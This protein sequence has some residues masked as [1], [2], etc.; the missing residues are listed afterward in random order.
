MSD[1]RELD[2]KEVAEDIIRRLQEW[3]DAHPLGTP[4]FRIAL[5][6]CGG[7]YLRTYGATA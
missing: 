2:W 1:P 3:E 6:E 4:C 5:D 7:Q